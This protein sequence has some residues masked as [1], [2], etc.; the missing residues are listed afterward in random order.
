MRKFRIVQNE[1]GEYAIQ[2]RVFLFFWKFHK[3]GG[4]IRIFTTKK[5]I[6]H[7]FDQFKKE[8]TWNEV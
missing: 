8:M 5:G 3:Q 4:Q 6:E 2:Y 1:L 7:Y